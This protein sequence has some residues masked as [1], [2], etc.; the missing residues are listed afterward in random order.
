M[1]SFSGRGEFITFE[2][3]KKRREEFKMKKILVFLMRQ[4]E[5]LHLNEARE[6][7]SSALDCRSILISE[8]KKNG[9]YHLV[10][11]V[12]CVNSSKSTILAIKEH[13]IGKKGTYFI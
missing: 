2:L 11:G 6:R 7:I 10:L 9:N 4:K 1:E 13:D 12:L 3:F 8:G 5:G